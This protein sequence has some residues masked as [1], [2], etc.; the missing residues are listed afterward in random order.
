MSILRELGGEVGHK[1]R[2]VLTGA[3]S[4]NGQDTSYIMSVK[5]A[6]LKV[7]TLGSKSTNMQSTDFHNPAG[8]QH[9]SGLL[10]WRLHALPLQAVT[11]HFFVQAFII[12]S[13]SSN[14]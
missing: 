11:F 9:N 4:L 6:V 12:I 8:Q 13:Q 1:D 10:V 14:F 7:P 2:S 3:F 5:K